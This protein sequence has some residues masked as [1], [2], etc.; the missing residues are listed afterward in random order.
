MQW[1]AVLCCEIVL[2]ESQ[3]CDSVDSCGG[4]CLHIWWTVLYKM[5]C[6]YAGPFSTKLDF[7][8]QN[9][10]CMCCAVLCKIIQN[11]CIDAGPFSTKWFACMHECS[12]KMFFNLCMPCVSQISLQYDIHFW[13]S[14]IY[15]TLTLAFFW[16][17]IQN[18]YNIVKTIEKSMPYK[19]I[20]LQIPQFFH[21]FVTKFTKIS[22]FST[23]SF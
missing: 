9:G 13:H 6:I 5:V 14:K 10:F 1:D 8:L 16:H 4:E 21:R 19:S 17:S 2:D 23:F 7:S 18:T 15:P 12:C 3:E 20:V 22:S 11:G